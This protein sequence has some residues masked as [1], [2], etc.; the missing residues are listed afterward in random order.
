MKKTEVIVNVIILLA[1]CCC[2][3]SYAQTSRSEI[4]SDATR[5]GVLVLDATPEIRE[6]GC[7]KLVVMDDLAIAYFRGRGGF[8]AKCCELKPGK[9]AIP[10][11]EEAR[12]KRGLP[13]GSYSG[14]DE[15]L[16]RLEAELKA[17]EE[18]ITRLEEEITRDKRLADQYPEYKEAMEAIDYL[19]EYNIQ[20]VVCNKD[21]STL[22]EC[23][24]GKY[25]PSVSKEECM[26]H[27]KEGG[28]KD[29]CPVLGKYR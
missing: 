6:K 13:P 3:P 19:F 2:A 22:K 26:E 15:D 28:Y 18:E 25:A 7:E 24:R 20:G 11:L 10:L 17:K 27:L 14:L 29:P 23:S 12:R 21:F 5:H 4:L 8:P 1:I 9:K 16:I